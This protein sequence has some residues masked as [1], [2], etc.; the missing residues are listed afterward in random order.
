MIYDSWPKAEKALI[1]SLE[2]DF[3]AKDARKRYDVDGMGEACQRVVVRDGVEVTVWDIPNNYHEFRDLVLLYA[4]PGVSEDDTI[5]TGEDQFTAR[6]R[7]VDGWRGMEPIGEWT[8]E[9]TG[10]LRE[11]IKDAEIELQGGNK[12]F[13]YSE[14]VTGVTDEDGDS[15]R[16]WR[17]FTDYLPI[18]RMN[19]IAPDYDARFVA[20]MNN[21][22]EQPVVLHRYPMPVY[23]DAVDEFIINRWLIMHLRGSIQP[24]FELAWA[25]I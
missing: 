1:K 23:P 19:E 4:Y 11:I 7:T 18:G 6:Y 16:G 24:F 13:I 9:F 15:V 21:D 8:R 10:T 14:L 17:W 3:M 22:L 12:N 25:W 2:D 20:Y 5:E